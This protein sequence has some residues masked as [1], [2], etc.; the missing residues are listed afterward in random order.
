M[1]MWDLK[2]KKALAARGSKGMEGK[3]G[4]AGSC[5]GAVIKGL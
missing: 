4:F 1:E 3:C 2:D 5:W